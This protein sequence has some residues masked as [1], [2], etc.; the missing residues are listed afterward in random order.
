MDHIL[1]KLASQL[2]IVSTSPFAL[3]G[4]LS[5]VIAWVA[6]GFRLRR[7]SELLRNIEKL[8]KKDRIKAFQS[9]IGEVPIKGGFTPE[10]Y[11][12]FRNHRYYF[13]AGLALLL[14][15]GY[16]S[17]LAIFSP[18]TPSRH[19]ISKDW[20]QYKLISQA[21]YDSGTPEQ[22]KEDCRTWLR[23]KGGVWNN[24]IADGKLWSENT[25][26]PT[27]IQ[28]IFINETD[29]IGDWGN[30]INVGPYNPISVDVTIAAGEPNNEF[31]SG[32]GLLF[33]FR[34]GNYYLYIVSTWGKLSFLQ[35]LNGTM[36][37]IYEQ[38]IQNFNRQ[39]EYQLGIAGDKERILLFFNKS[40]VQ[41]IGDTIN[42]RGPGGIVYLGKGRYGFDNFRIFSSI[43]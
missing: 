33:R 22:E 36:T 11:L 7:N 37:T 9:E 35:F 13:L 2:S 32:A 34:P 12:R 26:D 21:L 10:Q 4:Y 39:T 20:W 42:I 25:V 15:I 23:G 3:I 1:A 24:E 41:A 29:R 8:P 17:S 18:E 16:L 38:P 31:V 43:Q 28:Y 19:A 27:A 40:L 14:L 30:I 5:V 6:I